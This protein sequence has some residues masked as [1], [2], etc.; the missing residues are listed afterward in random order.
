MSVTQLISESAGKVS[1]QFLRY[2]VVGGIA[3]VIDFS[4]LVGLTQWLGMPYLVSAAVGFAVGVAVNYTLCLRWVFDTRRFR[5]RRLELTLFTS[6]GLSGL[7][8]NEV[9]LWFITEPLAQPYYISKLL[10]Y[11]TPSLCSP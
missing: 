8:L 11:P 10:A 6:I 9:L 4:L 3:F 7:M 1:G 2:L 5:D